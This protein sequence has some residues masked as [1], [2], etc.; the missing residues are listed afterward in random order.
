[1]VVHGV[2]PTRFDFLPNHFAFS[3][4][5]APFSTFPH[6]DAFLGLRVCCEHP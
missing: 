6:G 3:G 2:E 5:G 4:G 1:L